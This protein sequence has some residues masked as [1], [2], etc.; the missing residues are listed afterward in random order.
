MA[1]ETLTQEEGDAYTTYLLLKL[2]AALYKKHNVAMQIH[3]SCLRN[4]N[5]K[6]YRKLGPT[7][8]LT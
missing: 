4:V 3:Y 7:P 2:G 1:G 6:M 5:H 8:A